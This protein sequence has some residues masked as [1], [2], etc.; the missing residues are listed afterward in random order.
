MNKIRTVIIDDEQDACAL[1]DLLLTQFFEQEIEV[2]NSFQNSLEAFQYL[3]SHLVDLVFLDIDMP[4][5][6]GVELI[7]LFPNR[8]FE[9]IFVT[10]YGHHALKAFENNAL[11]YILK[12]IDKQIF[13]KSI[14]I[15]IERVKAIR[16]QSFITQQTEQLERI[17]FFTNGVNKFVSQHDI[18][19]C[20]AD[21]SYTQVFMKS[22]HFTVCKNLK[23]VSNDLNSSIFIRLN[24]S[25]LANL[26]HI[27]GY[28]KTYDGSVFMSDDYQISLSRQLKQ[29]ILARLTQ[30]VKP[31]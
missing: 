16:D 27:V 3:N 14:N 13:T 21:G 26:N 30:T 31:M 10:A 23:Q 2:V 22:E 9:V 25:F 24:R 4:E 15:A 1:L 20:K 19:Y 17:S 18:L 11:N 6:T 7:E 12:P 8:N 28:C 29:H 5:L